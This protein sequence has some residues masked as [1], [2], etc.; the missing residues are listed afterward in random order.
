VPP[1]RRREDTEPWYRQFWPW[2]LIALPGS[3]VIAGFTTLYIANRYS[4]DLVVQ[5]YYKDGLAIN[6]QLEKQARAQDLGVG[7][8]LL[9]LGDRVQVRLQAPSSA[10]GEP[11]TLRLLLSHPLES[12][13]DFAV[14]VERVAPTL[15][16]GAM[17]ASPAP[18]WHWTL[19]PGEGSWRLDGSLGPE[20]FLD[21]DAPDR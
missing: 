13:R 7:A 5:D 14:I 11:D 19:E 15:Y 12:D 8:S 6:Q 16:V 3:V 10:G 2:F 20:A 1:G 17:P 21:S 4:D 18:N 9:L